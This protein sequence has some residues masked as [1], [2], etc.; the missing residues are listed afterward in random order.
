MA[1]FSKGNAH[2]NTATTTSNAV[3]CCP[4]SDHSAC[5]SL[6]QRGAPRGSKCL[7]HDCS[8]KIWRGK[9][10]TKERLH[11][12]PPPS[13]KSR[14]ASRL[15]AFRCRCQCCAQQLHVNASAGFTRRPL[16]LTTTCYQ[17]IKW[18]WPPLPSGSTRRSSDSLYM[19]QRSEVALLGRG[20]FSTAPPPPVQTET[21]TNF[22][23]S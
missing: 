15:Q 11:I 17:T 6:H 14:Q 23:N 12:D 4:R 3:K 8:L 22:W 5:K 21:S 18:A 7:S 1:T 16:Y 9:T 13:A 19:L 20:A 2:R 10:A